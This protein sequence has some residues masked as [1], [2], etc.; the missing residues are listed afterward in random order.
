MSESKTAKVRNCSG[1]DLLVGGSLNGR[2]VLAGQAVEV[3]LEDV[4]AF[5]SQPGTW[6]PYDAA[7]KKVTKEGAEA[8]QAREAAENATAEP[9][10]GEPDESPEPNEPGPAGT[11]ED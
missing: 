2:L 1:E 6:E 3:P 5:T 7:S 10:S 8:E 4:W 11:Q 9:A